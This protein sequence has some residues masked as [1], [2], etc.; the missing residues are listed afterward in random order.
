MKKNQKKHTAL[1]LILFLA[2]FSLSFAQTVNR[3]DFFNYKNTTG[4][5]Y[6]QMNEVV[7]GADGAMHFIS[8]EGATRYDGISFERRTSPYFSEGNSAN[9]MKLTPSGKIMGVFGSK[10]IFVLD[11]WAKLKFPSKDDAPRLINTFEFVTAEKLWI[12]TEKGLFF[13]DYY[14]KKDSLEIIFCLQKSFDY[15]NILSL[16][17]DKKNNLVFGIDKEEGLFQIFGN[18]EFDPLN[19]PFPEKANEYLDFSVTDKYYF[20]LY[21]WTKLAVFDRES[22][23]LLCRFDFGKDQYFSRIEAISNSSVWIASPYSGLIKFSL[24]DQEGNY[25]FRRYTVLN[26][27]AS[28]YVYDIFKDN[29]GIFWFATNDGVSKL[30]SERFEQIILSNIPGVN[31]FPTG[32]QNH[33]GKTYTFSDPFGIGFLSSA[34]SGLVVKSVSRGGSNG[35]AF[36]GH[37]LNLKSNVLWLF[38]DDGI[39]YQYPSFSGAKIKKYKDVKNLNDEAIWDVY[40]VDNNRILLGRS[41]DIVLARMDGQRLKYIDRIEIPGEGA[42]VSAFHSFDSNE[43]VLVG[44]D[45]FLVRLSVSQKL[46]LKADLKHWFENPDF[47]IYDIERDKNGTWFFGTAN[48]GLIIRDKDEFYQYQNTNTVPYNTLYDL[49][50]DS[51]GNLWGGSYN[52]ITRMKYKGNGKLDSKHFGI[53]DLIP[54]LDINYHSI[55]ETPE[56]YILYGLPNAIGVYFPEKDTINNIR[57]EINISSILLN[58]KSVSKETLSNLPYQFIDLKIDFYYPVYFHEK[59]L[60]YQY[61]IDPLSSEWKT[62]LAPGQILI[63]NLPSGDYS[64]NIRV[65]DPGGVS[66]IETIQVPLRVQ[67]P[68]WQSFWF[69][70]FAL[71]IVSLLIY[72][73]WLMRIRRMKTVQRELEQVVTRRTLEISQKNTELEEKNTKLAELQKNKDEFISIVAHDLKNPINA[74]VNLARMI[75]SDYENLPNELGEDAKVIESAA[76]HMNNLV[77]NLLDINRI[78]AN[79]LVPHMHPI[80]VLSEI[81]KILETYRL[82]SWPKNIELKLE[83]R[84]KGEELIFGDSDSFSQICGN[85][86]SNAIK[87]SKPKSKVL[88]TLHSDDESVYV[89]IEDW[90]PGIPENLRERIFDKFYTNAGDEKQN[91]AGNGLGLTIVKKLIEL[92]NAQLEV[93]NHKDNIG[94]VFNLIFVRHKSMENER[95][96]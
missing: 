45:H 78:E 60:D 95:T 19:F 55:F 54:P 79:Q 1:I 40:A 77:K 90:G 33:N 35:I 36:Y 66:E 92:H 74:I 39:Y 34:G 10:F 28:N 59:Q 52:G 23:H 69:L 89:R 11:N 18:D 58:N 62:T 75:Q 4:L 88:I 14:K 27:L 3:S 53:Y 42:E 80:H 87:F 47:F 50:I 48:D 96:E 81:D 38:S 76:T 7:Q 67:Y 5:L 26:G 68:F 29:N 85:I 15:Q 94:A 91:K 46:K 20:V 51:H 57:D 65:V 70:L 24:L 17:N 25:E 44:G 56:G 72:S 12:A 30:A 63:S 9:S 86:I 61:K 93:S 6:S 82:L 8:M 2:L 84:L 73:I 31:G 43:D 41:S 21:N 83:H 16:K 49:F 71:V 22:H 64:L 32:W 13:T 37:Y